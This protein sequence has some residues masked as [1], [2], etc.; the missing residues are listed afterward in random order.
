VTPD[1]PFRQQPPGPDGKVQFVAPKVGEARLK[2]G[3]RVLLVERHDLPIVSVRLQLVLGA[4][5]MPELRPGTLSFTGSMLLEGTKKRTAL[6]I[7]DDFESIGA[8]FGTNVEW[9][10]VSV[11]VVRVLVD[12]LDPAL[13]LLA[14]VALSPTFPEA[15][16]DRLKNRR[17][18]AI[19][20]EK[21]APPTIAQ[22]AIAATLFGR[23]HPYGH[24][25]SGEEADA[26][27]LS[28]GEI[29]RAYDR[30]FAPANAT[31]IAAGDVTLPGLVS[32]LES[33]FGS[34]R[35][36]GTGAPR[37][38]PA[39]PKGADKLERRV[40][41]V[42]KPGAAQSQV[43]VVRIGAP[44]ASKDRDALAVA[45]TILGGSFSARLN[46]N[47][48]EK[49]SYTYGARTSFA[50]R[51]G[52]GPFTA[53][54]A[55]FTDKTGAAIKEI[56]AELE[57]LRR[58]GPTDEEMLV[59][60]ESIKGS[61]PARFE[62]TMEVTNAL[63]DLAVYDLPLDDYEKRPGRID[64]VTATDVKRVATDYFNP[65][66]MKIVI[67]GDKAAVLP[68]LEGLGLGPIDE[69]DAYGTP[70]NPAPPAKKPSAKK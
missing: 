30:A 36:R 26:K 8:Q 3:M 21:A 55:I 27:K 6:Q 1:A 62:T 51:H 10:S 68:Q 15:E 25:L 69:R 54:G 18:T 11:Q 29:L 12:Q 23:N 58:D 52:A 57:G 5:D 59:A 16:V 56:I 39:T 43:Q 14:D 9:D 45:N 4:G 67:V 40:V 60:K 32:R 24:S 22:N 49:H 63:A 7:S 2:N 13:E 38:A 46:M 64:A 48:R 65:E 17:L 31:I 28:R 50:L 44:H 19:T 53:G 37:R 41:F 66:T 47:L 70:L 33:T 42:D 34:W 20:A 61:M 35:G